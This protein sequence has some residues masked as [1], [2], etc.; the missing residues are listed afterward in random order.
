ML[1]WYSE[2]VSRPADS[3]APRAPDLQLPLPLPGL[4]EPPPG[5]LSIPRKDR[6]FANRNLHLAE[7]EWVG[8][9]MD[10]TLAIYEQNAMDTLSVRLTVERLIRRGYPESLR[11]LSFDT[12]FP[13]RGLLVDKE[14]GNILKLDR[15][16]QVAKGYHGTRLLER[17][18]IDSLYHENKLRYQSDRYHWIDTLF[19]LCEVTSYAAIVTA[20]DDDKISFDPRQLFVDVRTS[21]DEA[22]QDGSVYREVTQNLDRYLDR[23]PELPATLH[24]L[25]SAGKKLFVLTNSPWHYTNTIMT[26]LLGDAGGRYP[27][28]QGYFDIVICSARKPLWFADGTPFLERLPSLPPPDWGQSKVPGETK[29]VLGALERGRVYEGG[30][31]SEFEARLGLAGRKVLYVGDHIFGDILRSKKDSTWRTALVI[32]ELDQEIGALKTTLELRSR[33]RQLYEARPLI[34]DELRYYQKQ[35]RDLPKE[36]EG[37]AAKQARAQVKSEID[38]LKLEL[39]NL[40]AEYLSV[41]REHDRI[42][43]EYFGP[44]LKEMN[45][46]SVFGQQVETYAD[47]YLR[48]VSCLGLYSPTQFFRSPHD[49]LPHE[50]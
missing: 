32:Q 36:V 22:H 34:E 46:L 48:R 1:L 49:L 38:R 8:F 50:I 47:I 11:K 28:W 4:L 7:I 23:D 30:S 20:L 37:L 41:S 12:N 29:P 15:H 24:R 21:I 2:T 44:L 18:E 19:A 6:V 9:D 16:K 14:R 33:R 10:Y 39:E 13:I 40:E 17:A 45:G 26:Y 27:A 25:R 31:L 3:E 35:L 42:F 5:G 43:H